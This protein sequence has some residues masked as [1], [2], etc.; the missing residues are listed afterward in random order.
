MAI[1]KCE[2]CNH[3]FGEKKCLCPKC[4]TP[5]NNKTTRE[6]PITE[7]E[8]KINRDS[9]NLVIFLFIISLIGAVLYYL[10]FTTK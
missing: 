8:I 5:N 2:N 4:S 9:R 1:V 10:Y 7:Q 3:F 6:R